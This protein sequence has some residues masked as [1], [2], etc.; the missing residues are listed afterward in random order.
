[1]I[2]NDKYLL[3]ELCSCDT[4]LLPVYAP[5]DGVYTLTFVQNG[6]RI[7]KT[8]TRL[9]GEPFLIQAT[10]LNEWG[11]ADFVIQDSA[12]N[13][14]GM[15]D[16]CLWTDEFVNKWFS[17]W[18]GFHAETNPPV[19]SPPYFSDFCTDAATANAVFSGIDSIITDAIRELAGEGFGYCNFGTVFEEFITEG[20]AR[21][22]AIQ[23]HSQ[24]LPTPRGW[25]YQLWC[26]GGI[27]HF[28][29][30]LSASP[31]TVVN[32]IISGGFPPYTVP[33]GFIKVAEGIGATYN[34]YRE[35]LPTT[36][37]SIKDFR[38]CVKICY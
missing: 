5:A 19:P 26:E 28:E 35:L 34:E 20:D 11:C 37:G 12:G 2:C 32:P 21:D 36:Q 17:F 13:L 8:Q 4:A 23:L 14:I 10:W 30:Y 16:G 7:F 31:Q 3:G 18:A 15:Y 1:M 29:A 38:V 27:P 25:G 22:G 6:K 24:T 9:T 33:T